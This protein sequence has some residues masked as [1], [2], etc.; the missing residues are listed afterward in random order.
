[1][2]V[3]TFLN[4][5]IL[6]VLRYSSIKRSYSLATMPHF[7]SLDDLKISPSPTFT[8]YQRRRDLL[9]SHDLERA[10]LPAGFPLHTNSPSVWSGGSLDIEK[11]AIDLTHAEIQ[12]IEE[13][14]HSFK[15]TCT[16]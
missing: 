2:L 13:A 16:F 10:E 7:E 15:G 6:R 3:G 5:T 4:F 14:L 9:A 8:Q 11:L 1:M 12:E